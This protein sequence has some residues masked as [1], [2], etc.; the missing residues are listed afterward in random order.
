MM[1]VILFIALAFSIVIAIFAVQNTAQW[2]SRSLPSMRR[3][4]RSPSWC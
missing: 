2:A 3:R 4:S 1:Q